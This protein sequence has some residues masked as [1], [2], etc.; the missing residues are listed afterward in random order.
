M[1]AIASSMNAPWLKHG[2]IAETFID[3]TQST[4]TGPA[5]GLPG[6]APSGPSGDPSVP[7]DPRHARR[8]APVNRY[9]IAT[10]HSCAPCAG[11]AVHVTSYVPAAETFFTATA[12]CTSAPACRIA[13]TTT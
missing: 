6:H 7:A 2:M 1:L 3:T 5:H 10:N 13:S 8:T 11:V 12:D 4:L 9:W